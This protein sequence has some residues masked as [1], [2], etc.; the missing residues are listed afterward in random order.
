[1]NGKVSDIELL[2]ASVSDAVY[3]S[4]FVGPC[5]PGWGPA[6]LVDVDVDVGVI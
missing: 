4:P 1:M 5:E 2:W 3:L 6:K